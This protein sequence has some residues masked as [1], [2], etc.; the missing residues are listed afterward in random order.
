MFNYYLAKGTKGIISYHTQI[1]SIDS[2]TYKLQCPKH[3]QNIA[4]SSLSNFTCN[5]VPKF[6]K[7]EVEEFVAE[8]ILISIAEGDITKLMNTEISFD[9]SPYNKGFYQKERVR[10][11]ILSYCT[12]ISE[13]NGIV[14]LNYIGRPTSN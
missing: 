1:D 4:I 13:K 5:Y 10:E 8:M 11:L 12:I 7:Y 3:I 2:T 14:E 9:D 6:G